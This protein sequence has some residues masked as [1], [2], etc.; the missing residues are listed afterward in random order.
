MKMKMQMSSSL[1]KMKTRMRKTM[2]RSQ[3]LAESKSRSARVL[4]AVAGQQQA[5][6]PLGSYGIRL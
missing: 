4:L 3:Y 1:R 6:R 2:S 5:R